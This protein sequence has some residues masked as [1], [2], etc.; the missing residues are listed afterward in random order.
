MKSTDD[1]DVV[2][3][4]DD[5]KSTHL[6]SPVDIPRTS[7]RLTREALE[8]KRL[9]LA[10]DLERRKQLQDLAI[11]KFL[12]YFPCLTLGICCLITLAL[13]VFQGFH[14]AGFSLDQSLMHW[15]GGAT[16]GAIGGLAMI[17]YKRRM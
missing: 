10:L 8:L 12:V 1:V 4:V 14:T 9:A 11:Q 3:K 7:H 13:F 17:V 15:M 2:E 5:A 16:I 6:E